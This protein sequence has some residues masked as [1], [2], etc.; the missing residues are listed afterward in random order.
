MIVHAQKP[1]EYYLC[2]ESQPEIDKAKARAKERGEDPETYEPDPDEIYDYLDVADAKIVPSLV[3]SLR[4][5]GVATGHIQ[6]HKRDN[7]RDDGFVD[8]GYY[9][10]RWEWDEGEI[11]RDD[12]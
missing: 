7:I 2:F 12:F 4:K 9:F 6:L 8:G 11:V 5:R 3:K 10:Q 1:T